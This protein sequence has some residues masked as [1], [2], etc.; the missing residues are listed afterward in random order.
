MASGMTGTAGFLPAVSAEP[1]TAHVRMILR[2]AKGFL[3]RLSADEFR[4]AGS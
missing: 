2:D 1:V 3:V 4:S